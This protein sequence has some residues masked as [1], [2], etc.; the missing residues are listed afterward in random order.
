MRFEELNLPNEF[1]F[2]LNELGL[3]TCTE[4][5]EK[6]IPLAMQGVD[7]V[8]RSET[9]SGK[10]FAFA[11]PALCGV[12]TEDRAT[13]VLV[14]CPTRE[15]CVQTVKEFRKL[16]VKKEGCRAVAVYGGEGMERQIFDL[17]KGARIV[18]GTPG[19]ILDHIDRR[20]LKLGGVKTLIFDEA[21]EMLSMGFQKEIDKV[22]KKVNPDRQTLMLSATMPESVKKLAQT[23][24]KN[25]VTVEVAP[26][27]L[28]IYH[29]YFTVGRKDKQRALTEYLTKYRPHTALIFCNTKKMADTLSNYLAGEGV[30]HGLIHGE[31]PQP[32]RI[33]AMEDMKKEGGYLVATDVAARGIDIQNVDVVINFDMPQ[34][35]E[36]FAHRVG[37][38][39][40][41]GKSG[42]AVTFINT[43]PQKGEYTRLLTE[44]GATAKEG[45]L[46]AS[47]TYEE[48]LPTRGK[49][50]PQGG[51]RP[52]KGGFSKGKGEQKSFYKGGETPSRKKREGRASGLMEFSHGKPKATSP[53]ANFSKSKGNPSQ[54]K[55]KP[56]P[57]SGNKG[58]KFEKS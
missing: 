32:R 20:V 10:T 16:C 36:I 9:G 56:S 28:P 41:A 42:S 53:K 13:Q 58:K 33:R 19:R 7:I 21:D 23:Y 3:T 47:L 11:L 5:Q 12:N 39:A 29:T 49:F 8:A 24:L 2:A 55:G 38:T 52:V 27:T 35:A 50:A 26:K 51:N 44:I 45:K 48:E 40:R 57:K 17:K 4:I 22:L 15:L 30:P 34:S 14:L 37:R 46:S 18:V 25:P 31:I 1:T 6:M 43:P 54:N